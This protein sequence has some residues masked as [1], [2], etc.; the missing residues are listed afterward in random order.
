MSNLK[1]KVLGHIISN[2]KTINATFTIRTEDGEVF[3][4]V[5]EEQKKKK[6]SPNK[7]PTGALTKHFKPQ[8]KEPLEPGMAGVVLCGE[9]EPEVLRSSLTAYLASK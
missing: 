8:L 3:T 6:R 7:Y 1:Q 4:N 9:Y 5:V 2:L